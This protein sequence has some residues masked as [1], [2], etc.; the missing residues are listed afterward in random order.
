M[1]QPNLDQPISSAESAALDEELKL[2]ILKEAK[3]GTWYDGWTP[4]CAPCTGLV[5]MTQRAYGF[6]CPACRN[7]I[8]WNLY[9]LT[10]SPL[11]R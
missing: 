1:N 3:G 10:D 8:G 7:M 9:R 6:E 5:R 11:N 2:S 4:Y